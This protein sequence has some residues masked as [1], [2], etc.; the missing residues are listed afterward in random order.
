M[1]FRNVLAVIYLLVLVGWLVLVVMFVPSLVLDNPTGL[2][3][4]LALVAG[5]GVGGVT[6]FFMV[7]GTLIFQFYFRKSSTKE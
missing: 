2:D 6:Q 3:P 1:T 4:I 5:L 7:V